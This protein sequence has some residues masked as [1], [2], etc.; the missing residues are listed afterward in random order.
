V[1]NAKWYTEC[2]TQVVTRVPEDV[3]RE[4]DKLVESGDFESRSDAV[5]E[6]LLQLIDKHRRE[7]I[8]RQIVEGYKRIPQ[9]DG[10]VLWAESATRAMI[11]E[12]PW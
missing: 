12:E 3:L 6:A 7:Q 1:R 4:L 2:M 5:R 11:E 10:E 9:T 8:G